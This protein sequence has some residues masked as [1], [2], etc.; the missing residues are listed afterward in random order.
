MFAKLFGTRSK[1]P[2]K[3]NIK[4]K[5][6]TF[7]LPIKDVKDIIIGNDHK[8]KL[9][10]KVTPINGELAPEDMLR[11]ISNAIQGALNSFEGRQG[12]YI[13]S[14]RVDISLN[15]KNIEKQ[16]EELSDEFR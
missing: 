8:Y 3:N 4:N 7:N 12:I 13:Q 9:V 6:E 15:I 16:K 14:E 10:A 1:I 5:E 11:D 2:K